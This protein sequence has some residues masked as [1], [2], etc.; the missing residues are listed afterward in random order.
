MAARVPKRVSLTWTND[1]GQSASITLDA[2]IEEHHKQSSD[3]TEHPVEIGPNVSDFVRPQPFALEIQGVISNTPIVLPPAS[4]MDG[5]RIVPVSVDG[6]P[7]TVGN[8]LGRPLPGFNFIAGQRVTSIPQRKAATIGF[9]P[10]FDRATKVYNL[11][12]GLVTE[13]VLLTVVTA[14]ATWEN[15]VLQSA[16]ITRNAQVGDAL[17]LNLS[18]RQVR[19]AEVDTVEVPV[20]PT[21]KKAKGNKPTKPASPAPEPEQESM[22]HSLFGDD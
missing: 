20:L 8:T 11:V 5:S 9:D 6:P 18:L 10:E 19:L 13:G 12:M 2:S 21:T 1:L 7:H 15:M 17:D 16:D 14:I 22:L 4:E 3:V